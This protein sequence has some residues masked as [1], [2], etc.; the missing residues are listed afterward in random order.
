[1]RGECALPLTDISLDGIHV[2]S[3]EHLRE[4]IRNATIPTYVSGGA[5]GSMPPTLAVVRSDFGEILCYMLNEDDH[6][7]RFGYKSVRDR[8][9]TELPG[10]GIDAV[11]VEAGQPLSLVLG[12]VKVSNENA[13]PPQVVD[14]SSDSLGQQQRGHVGDLETTGKKIWDLARRTSDQQT[15]ELFIQAALYFDDRRWD[16]LRLVVCCL[17]G[18]CAPRARNHSGMVATNMAEVSPASDQASQ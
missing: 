9:L 7:T 16:K 17:L 1:M 12:E 5:A 18:T 11:G 14:S 8:E 15:R 3:V 13:S 6:D 2:V 4:R 10:R